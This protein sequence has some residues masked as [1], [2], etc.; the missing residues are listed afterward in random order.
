MKPVW[1]YEFAGK[2]CDIFYDE[3][4]EDP[5]ECY[6]ECNYGHLYTW[7]KRNNY[8]DEHDIDADDFDGWKSIKAY[9]IE[10]FKSVIILPVYMFKH[11]GI[12]LSTAPFGDPWDSGQIGFIWCDE[13]DVKKGG[14]EITSE[15]LGIVEGCLVGEVATYSDYLNGSVFWF[16]LIDVASGDEL[17]TS[18]G[19]YGVDFKENG[20]LDAA[21]GN[22][23]G[24][25]K[26]V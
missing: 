5:R 26:E 1:S 3:F 12:A 11:T 17:E 7:T 13:E 6:K 20:L 2:R 19:Y 10:A 15:S 18:G 21:F 25:A 24:Q 22:D 8:G 16:K 14:L 4:A 9:L 23:S